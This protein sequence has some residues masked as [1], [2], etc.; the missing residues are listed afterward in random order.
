MAEPLV[1]ISMDQLRL[2]LESVGQQTSSRI[3]PGSFSKC[4][5]R[6]SGTTDVHAFVDTIS[7]Y[8]D[9]ESISDANA[10]RGLTMLL[11]EPALTWWYGVK[12]TTQSW[13]DAVALL[14]ST[15]GPDRPVHK[16]L[17]EFFSKE[18]IDAQNTELFVAGKRALIAKIPQTSRPVETFQIDMVYALLLQRVKQALPR[19]KFNTFATMLEELRKLEEV[20]PKPRMEPALQPIKKP[21]CAY[22]K[23]NGHT[24]E[25]CRKKKRDDLN[26]GQTSTQASV[27]TST[28]ASASKIS[29]FGCGEPG[30]IKSNCPKCNP[31][32]EDDVG[33]FLA[34]TIPNTI[35]HVSRPVVT[36]TVGSVTGG[37]YLD[38][39][40]KQNIAGP[41][42]HQHLKSLGQ[43][44]TPQ[45]VN[46][47]LADGRERPQ[48]VLV[49]DATIQLEHKAVTTTFLVI[50]GAQNRTLL[51][52]DFIQK[53]GLILDI[54]RSQW[55]FAEKPWV[56]RQF[57]P[58][59]AASFLKKYHLT[60]IDAYPQRLQEH[61]TQPK[62]DDPR[63][64][65]QKIKNLFGPETPTRKYSTNLKNLCEPKTPERHTPKT[66]IYS[67]FADPR[68][69]L[70]TPLD[71]SPALPA[72][73]M[74]PHSPRR[75]MPRVDI[76][77]VDTEGI[78]LRKDEASSLDS[79][80]RRR[81]ETLIV[82]NTDI[83]QLGGDATPYGEHRIDTGDH[84]PIAVPPYRLPPHKQ[85]IL[86]EEIYK[87]I[88]LKVIEE[89]E[90]AWAAPV[91]LVPKPDQSTRVCIDYRKL[92]SVTRSDHYPLPRM[93]DLL[94][95]A[96]AA[97]ISTIDL[98]SG[99]WQIAMRPEDRDKTA[100]VTP[101]GLFRFNRMPFGL[102]NAPATFQRT[103]DRF[104]AGLQN[105]T[106]LAY[107]D[108]IIILSQSAEDHLK[109]LDNVFKKLR[110]F[111]LHARRSKCRFACNEVKYL[112][113]LITPQGLSVDPEKT[114][115]ITQLPPPKHVKALM[116]FLQTCSWYRRF[117]P[118][119]AAT[120]KPLSNLLKK[121]A[122]WTWGPSQ[123]EAFK[124][125][126]TLLVSPPILKQ[127]DTTQPFTI[128]TDA[129]GYALGAVLCQGQGQDERPV[130]Y[131]SR[132]LTAAE[133]NYSTTE[134]EAL[135][136][137][138]ALSK[139][140]GYIEGNPITLA[141]DHQPLRWLMT[142]KTPSGRLARWALSLQPYDL[143]IVYTP[144]KNNVVADTLSRPPCP[145][146]AE[147][148]CEICTVT[149]DIPR[150]P[151]NDIREAQLQDQ[152]LKKIIDCFEA[153]QPTPV[154]YAR[155]TNRGYIMSQG[156]LYRYSPDSESEEAQLVVPE[157]E[158]C[159]V[160]TEYHDTPTAGHYGG[161]RTYTR[162]AT[163]YF[164]VGMKRQILEYVKNCLECQRYKASNMKPSGLL[165]TPTPA[166]RFEHLSIDLFGPLPEA[167]G[168]EKWV[169][170]VE[171]TSTRWVEMFA[172]VQADAK[173]CAQTLIQEIFLRYGTPRRISSDNGTQFVSGIMQYVSHCLDIKQALTPF[174][175]PQANPV[176]RK[177]RDL[178]PQL[179]ILVQGAHSTWPDKL[180]A[181][182]FAMNTAL[183]QTTG[184]TAAFLTFGRELR[185]TDDVTRDQR[186]IIKAENFVPEIT[187][188][189][190]RLT[191]A[192]REARLLEEQQ[193]DIR[194]KYADSHRQEGPTYQPGD[195]VWVTSHNLSN[196]AKG[197]TAKFSP[198]RDGPY[199]IL[200]AKS[201][202]T[203]EVTD[204]S[205]AGTVVGTYHVSALGPYHGPMETLPVAV[206]PIRRRGRPRKSTTAVSGST[207]G[208]L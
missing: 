10:L 165:Q 148:T 64:L 38:T 95:T 131:A 47:I 193:Q 141:T 114:Q 146:H 191:D 204:P 2:L 21:R 77:M 163:R 122:I 142:L 87:M 18:Q 190:I 123:E 159:L 6:F 58:E 101:F 73:F 78:S 111:K 199:Q 136:V 132:L 27:S 161:E 198:K 181:I 187:P 71:D 138:W 80:Q 172:L 8:K 109:D 81:L 188:Y 205:N 133:K 92:N 137:V 48:E 36:I 108:D 166:Q 54:A 94:H 1:Q 139:F 86:R 120:A 5:T 39:G 171:D 145:P 70:Y 128:R 88:Q 22:C 118:N 169:F 11:E 45:F 51:G 149:V 42:L 112:G 14:K 85:E 173:T 79:Q 9:C 60:P 152:E 178:K 28:P 34:N 96:R 170:I 202:T 82:A 135:A 103:I 194:K 177:N 4:T 35:S 32:H 72:T 55:Y 183:C 12:D 46:L 76:A 105:T 97:V 66:D 203:Y 84:P 43:T 7:I 192:V 102:R 184:S 182:R 200:Q 104:R 65:S 107:L 176:E 44:F 144:G 201:P 164:W 113:H 207:S 13:E 3:T 180:P 196:A 49:T 100:F 23:L 197:I 140:R 62:K 167:Q 26:R 185:T 67:I 143:Q 160:L 93:D 41:V 116:S 15:Y 130:E 75:K 91:V 16:I 206:Q 129:S 115:A 40:A 119:F 147:E 189:L 168:K 61:T 99:Y 127:A 98:Q 106:V 52:I 208:R 150:R 25:E 19:S 33:F 50:P 124:T 125:L 89:C 30:F 53:A 29:C 151:A 157:Q 63:A 83:F 175:H 110:Q 195:L 155:W 37:A 31:R 162:I 158:R 17:K 154:D 20:T 57:R 153:K 186:A 121:T 56:T 59:P 174:Y 126:K 117:V 24:K 156:I 68:S 69:Q 90:S 179:A 134:R 74:F